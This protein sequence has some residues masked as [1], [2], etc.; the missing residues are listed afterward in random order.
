V[1]DCFRVL[2]A[3]RQGGG[4][5]ASPL[6]ITEI[7][8]VMNELGITDRTVR[9]ETIDHL[10]ALDRAYLEWSHEQHG[11]RSSQGNAKPRH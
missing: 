3:T 11:D 4:F 10:L 7:A 2:S 8:G 6:A 5:G 9:L 1:L